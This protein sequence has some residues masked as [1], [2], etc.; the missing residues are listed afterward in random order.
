MTP[1][2][3]YA[4][5]AASLSRRPAV[6]EGADDK[7]RARNRFGSSGLKVDGKLFAMLVRGRFVVKLPRGRVD[8][9]VAAGEGERFDPR[10]DGRV[11]K[12]WLVLDPSSGQDWRALAE[13][14]LEFVGSQR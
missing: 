3:R 1:E 13:E 9:L 8:A 10:R 7:G 14:A 6:S 5:V 11:M 4:E 12:E 2:E